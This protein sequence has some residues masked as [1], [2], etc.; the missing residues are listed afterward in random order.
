VKLKLCDTLNSFGGEGVHVTRDNSVLY[1]HTHTTHDTHI[2]RTHTRHTH[3]THTRHTHTTHTQ[4]TTHDTH[5]HDTAAIL[6]ALICSWF[7]CRLHTAT[8]Y[9]KEVTRL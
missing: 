2:R 9:F 5:T 4:H 6:P 3:D 8:A 7:T 1:K